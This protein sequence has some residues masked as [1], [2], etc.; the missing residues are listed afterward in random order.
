[1]RSL[2]D[3]GTFLD[4]GAN[5]GYYTL[6]FAHH[7]Y[8]VLAVEPMLLNRKAI[9]ASLC[10]NPRLASRVKLLP[11]ALGAPGVTKQRCVVRADDRNA[12]NGKL[13]CSEHERCD[14]ALRASSHVSASQAAHSTICEPVRM[15]TLDELL[16]QHAELLGPS[17]LVA[18]KLDVRDCWDRNARLA[19]APRC[20]IIHSPDVVFDVARTCR[21]RASSATCLQVGRH[22]SEHP[23]AYQS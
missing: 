23:I 2:P 1:M 14:M 5:L 6:L 21:L 19:V 15:G 18:A 22:C 7:G 3:A 20:A 8:H 17:P 16:R 9:T 12:G 11:V 13:S 4:V 10:A